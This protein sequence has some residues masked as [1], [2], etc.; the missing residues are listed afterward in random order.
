MRRFLSARGLALVAACAA[1][2][3][4]ITAA[5]KAEPP[6]SGVAT[7]VVKTRGLDLSLATDRKQLTRRIGSAVRQLCGDPA[8]EELGR[9]ALMQACRE[10]AFGSA[11]P[12]VV[13]LVRR[14]TEYAALRAGARRAG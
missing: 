9:W 12:Q 14:D 6:A 8:P 1:S 5:A 4:L 11:A 10:A 7:V 2:A 13:A 3:V